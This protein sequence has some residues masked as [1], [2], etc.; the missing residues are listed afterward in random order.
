[1]GDYARWAIAVTLALLSG[2]VI[3]CQYGALVQTLLR[4]RENPKAGGYSMVPIIGGAL[5]MIA[6][7]VAPSASIQRLWWIAPICDPGCALLVTLLLG[8]IMW[9][10]TFGRARPPTPP[11][12]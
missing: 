10:V 12:R 2:L 5:G 3:I 6:C 8:H 9:L 7:L 4:Q 1:M 11:A